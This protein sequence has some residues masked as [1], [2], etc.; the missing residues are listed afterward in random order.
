MKH[1]KVYED[2]SDEELDGL[3]GDLNGVGLAGKTKIR[4]DFELTEDYTWGKGTAYGVSEDPRQAARFALAAAWWFY[5]S[6]FL[7]A[8]GLDVS[9]PI[10][11]EADIKA[12]FDDFF[13][14]S[15]SGGS[16]MIKALEEDLIKG[17][18]TRDLFE[19]A[20]EWVSVSVESLIG[21]P[22]GG[23]LEDIDVN[24]ADGY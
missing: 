12:V 23:T 17:R 8:G 11:T 20:V 6:E 7:D 2:Y 10:K 19:G 5:L 24:D 4:I 14:E 18:I 13:Q 15:P 16:S 22:N 21:E 3:M 9:L 1:I